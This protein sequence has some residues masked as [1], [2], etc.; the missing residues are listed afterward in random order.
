MVLFRNFTDNII[1]LFTKKSA[2]KS[3]KCK[4]HDSKFHGIHFINFFD[5]ENWGFLQNIESAE[6]YRLISFG[7]Q[8]YE[9]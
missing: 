1:Y 2:S 9:K 7:N 3:F 6:R 5:F 8:L 4:S